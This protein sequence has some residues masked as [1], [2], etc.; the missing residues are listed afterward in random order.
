SQ[1]RRRRSSLPGRFSLD[2]AQGPVEGPNEDGHG[3]GDDAPEGGSGIE[4]AASRGRCRRRDEQGILGELAPGGRLCLHV[5][6]EGRLDR[7]GVEN[8]TQGRGSAMR[9]E[10]GE[11]EDGAG[12]HGSVGV[13]PTSSPAAVSKR[14][15][16]LK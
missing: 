15:L 10:I 9:S 8:G 3:K 2:P 11:G 7:G 12:F 14:W 4:P 6:P 13:G 16:Y 1:S 5:A